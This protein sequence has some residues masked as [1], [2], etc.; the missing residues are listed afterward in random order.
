LMTILRGISFPAIDV[1]LSV[2]FRILPS[3]LAPPASSDA[4]G[5]D[6]TAP[7]TAQGL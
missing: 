3:I 2:L 7:F 6:V 1:S 4:T 5:S